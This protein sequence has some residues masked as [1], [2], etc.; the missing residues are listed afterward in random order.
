MARRSAQNPRYRK[1]AQIGKTRKSAASAKPKREIGERP[2]KA[3]GSSAGKTGK[4]RP[5]GGFRDPDT[6]EFKRWRKI[7]FV[8]LVS[9]MVFSLGAWVLRDL[10]T[11]NGLTLGLAYACLFGAF[12]IDLTKIR[13]MRKTYDAEHWAKVKPKKDDPETD[14]AKE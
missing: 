13:R 9:A 10:Q 4:G 6:P 2:V 12:Y 7:W 5:P 11:V 1:D 14:D 3:T 8:L